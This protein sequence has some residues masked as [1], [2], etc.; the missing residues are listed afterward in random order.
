[1]GFKWER[2]SLSLTAH[3]SVPHFPV[4][5]T[6]GRQ[7]D[8][9]TGFVRPCGGSLAQTG[10]LTREAELSLCEPL[11]P[12]GPSLS[13]VSVLPVEGPLLSLLSW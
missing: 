9:H 12:H 4:S 10:H 5:E 7:Q 3:R 2:L 8:F 13:R 1:M 6:G 11:P